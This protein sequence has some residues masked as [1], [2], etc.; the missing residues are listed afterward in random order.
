MTS[1][2]PPSPAKDLAADAAPGPTPVAAPAERWKQADRDQR[3]SLIVEVAM[4]ML[5]DHGPEAVTMRRVSSA[6]GVGAMTL[7]TY[8]DSQSDLHRAMV[9]QGF[10]IIHQTCAAACCAVQEENQD[11]H[12]WSGG[13]RAYIRFAIDHPNLYRLMFATPVDEDDAQF[14]PIMRGGLQPLM[15]VVRDRLQAQGLAGNHLDTE[16]KRA[17]GRYWIALHGLASLAIADRIQVLHGTLDEVLLH[18][19]EAVAPTKG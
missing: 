10:A 9:A 2:N 12:D 1:P 11:V 8:V 13:A 5:R 18:L 15:D 4:E 14:D 19:L 7:Y 6:I 16:S 17:A 3:R